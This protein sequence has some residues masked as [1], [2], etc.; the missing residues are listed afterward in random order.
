MVGPGG[1]RRR[2]RRG[3]VLNR[4]TIR[5]AHLYLGALF[6]PVLLLFT[7]SGAWQVF[8]WN[9]A[10]KDGTYTPP[11]VIQVVSSIHRDSTL[12]RG[13]PPSTAFKVFAFSACGALVATTILGVVM[14]YRFTPNPRLVTFCILLGIALPVLLLLVR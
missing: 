7:V 2:A 1:R 13:V 6:A 11:R 5:R 4:R 8:R 9:D 12:S 14:A 3:F 10:R